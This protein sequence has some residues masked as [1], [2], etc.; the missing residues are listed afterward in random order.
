MQIYQGKQHRMYE[1]SSYFDLSINPT[2]YISM[3]I[4]KI[5]FSEAVRIDIQCN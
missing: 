4:L 3:A 2:I 5:T 1:R